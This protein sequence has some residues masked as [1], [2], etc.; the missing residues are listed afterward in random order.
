MSK[1]DVINYVMTTPNNPNRAVL[2]G[3]LDSMA[4]AS[5]SAV[6]ATLN[7]TSETE[8]TCSL[9]RDE[10]RAELEKKNP[11]ILSWAYKPD[12]F[13]DYMLLGSSLVE[14][15]TGIMTIKINGNYWWCTSGNSWASRSSN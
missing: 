3:M 2:E 13:P 8:A 11:V 7:I 9:S 10:I 12:G 5:S 15:T 6:F 4:D 1:E 14:E